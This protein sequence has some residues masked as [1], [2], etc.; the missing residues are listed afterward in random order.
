MADREPSPSAKSG[1]AIITVQAT[2]PHT[3]TALCVHRRRI[4]WEHLCNT[5]VF[6]PQIQWRPK[7]SHEKTGYPVR[8][9]CPAHFLFEPL[10]G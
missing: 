3:P 7:F 10:S 8:A 9:S 6:S 1:S 4:V 5:Y 2:V